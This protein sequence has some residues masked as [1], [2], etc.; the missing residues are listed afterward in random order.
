MQ[1]PYTRA[2]CPG[3]F[4]PLLGRIVEYIDD[5]LVKS[6]SQRDHSVKSSISIWSS[7]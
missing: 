7:Q 3:Y 4:E 2:C 6:K 5:I 1:E